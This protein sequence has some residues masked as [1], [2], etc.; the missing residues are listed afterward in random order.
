[1]HH[2][3]IQLNQT[4]GAGVNRSPWS[5]DELRETGTV[6]AARKI[7]EQYFISRLNNAFGENY[8]IYL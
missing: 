2:I 6:L 4:A 5:V 1:M 8:G 7:S 3:H